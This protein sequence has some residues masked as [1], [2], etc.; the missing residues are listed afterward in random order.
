MVSCIET[1]LARL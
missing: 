1:K